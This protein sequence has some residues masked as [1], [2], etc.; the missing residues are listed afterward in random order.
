MI[1]HFN[2]AA[3]YSILRYLK[4]G[5]LF[6]FLDKDTYTDRDE[7]FSWRAYRLGVSLRGA[8]PLANDWLTLYV[9]ADGGLAFAVTHYT[10]TEPP[11]LVDDDDVPSED[12]KERFWGFHVAGG[13][14]VQFTPWQWAGFFWQAEYIYAPVIDNLIGDTHDS[15]GGVVVTGV[16]GGF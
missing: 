8:L 13:G 10:N 14:G 3:Y 9:Q 15:G 16:L 1:F 2:G 7:R 12:F 4:A 5:L 11:L 6:S